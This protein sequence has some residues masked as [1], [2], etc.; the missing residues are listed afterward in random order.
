ML[1]PAAI[2]DLEDYE[3]CSTKRMV[4]QLRLVLE[5]KQQTFKVCSIQSTHS[6]RHTMFVSGFRF[7]ASFNQPLQGLYLSCAVNIEIWFRL[8]SISTGIEFASLFA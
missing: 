5:I 4:S 8:Q 2:V 1:T 6:Y 3:A 7:G